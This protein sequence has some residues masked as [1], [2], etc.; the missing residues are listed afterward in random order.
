[1]PW[2]PTPIGCTLTFLDFHA[3]AGR[4]SPRVGSKSTTKG[5]RPARLLIHA[6]HLPF[7]LTSAWLSPATSAV[8]TE[9]ER[10]AVPAYLSLAP[11]CIL[12]SHESHLCSNS[13]LSVTHAELVPWL[14]CPLHSS[15]SAIVSLCAC[16][17]VVAHSSTAIPPHSQR[18]ACCGLRLNTYGAPSSCRVIRSFTYFWCS[19]YGPSSRLVHAPHPP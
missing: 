2:R 3:D 11:Y 15:V 4:L 13:T 14:A 8:D 12:C 5:S 7:D 6:I 16:F 10:L 9:R 19:A 18:G 1:M 17:L